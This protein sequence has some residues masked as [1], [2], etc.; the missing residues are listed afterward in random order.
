MGHTYYRRQLAIFILAASVLFTGCTTI[1]DYDNSRDPFER[2]NRF[3]Y[4]INDTVDNA[5]IKPLA[6]GYKAVLPT[7]VNRGITNVFNNLVDL[8]SVLNNLLQFK[9]DQ[10]VSGLGRVLVNSTVG[11]LGVA[12]IASKYDLPRYREDFGQTLG[13][14]GINAGPYIVLPLLGAS[15]ARDAFGLVVDWYVDP[16]RQIDPERTRWSITGLRGIDRRSDLLAASRIM[17][18]A[19]LDKYEFYRDAYLQ[20]R[21]SDVYDGDPPFEDM[22]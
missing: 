15:D 19:A 22:E 11:V 8:T 3:M 18:E 7:P 13:Y 4:N 10:A 17:E 20:K 14:W 1:N 9:F 21:Q 16:I 6:T 12:D 5:L 2:Y